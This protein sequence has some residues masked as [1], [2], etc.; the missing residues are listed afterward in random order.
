MPTLP[1]ELIGAAFESLERSTFM[2]GPAQDGGYYAVGASRG[3]RPSFQ[4][5]RWSTENALEDTVK[6]NAPRQPALLPPWYD[7]DEPEDLAVLRAHLA[8]DAALAPATAGCMAEIDR[9]QR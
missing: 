4:G 9:A 7:I 2:L 1:I 6:A 8:F 5:V 3:V